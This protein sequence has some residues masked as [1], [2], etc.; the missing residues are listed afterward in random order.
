MNNNPTTQ[1]FQNSQN[2]QV[3]D[4]I[5][6]HAITSGVSEAPEETNPDLAESLISWTQ[7]RDP[8]NLGESAIVSS[9]EQPISSDSAP[10]GQII[11]LTP[12]PGYDISEGINADPQVPNEAP[13][14]LGTSL[15]DPSGKINPSEI[16]S[17][18]DPSNLYEKMLEAREQFKEGVKS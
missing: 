15:I 11:D 18:T 7:E 8:R 17:S 14:P 5:F 4:D 6:K 16:N 13:N 12:P 10:T 9:S 2:T 1:N 3:D